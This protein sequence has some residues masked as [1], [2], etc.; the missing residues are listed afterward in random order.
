MH[1]QEEIRVASFGELDVATL[2][3]I[4]KLRVDVFVVEQ[5]CAYPELDGR[6]DEPGTRHVWL[7][8]GDGILAYLRILDD[9]GTAR[10]GR[11][12]TAASARQGG[13]ASRLLA[14]ALTVVGDRPAT[15]AAQAHLT[16]FYGR[17]GFEVAGEAYDEDGIPH[18][19]MVRA[20]RRRSR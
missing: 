16:G 18:V 7:A 20:A 4:L 5:N 3:A 2:Y 19:P 12:V 1:P 6:D 14:H 11:V 10:I 9:H 15:L 13:A 8:R 17:F